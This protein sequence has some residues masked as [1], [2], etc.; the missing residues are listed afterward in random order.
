MLTTDASPVGLG[1]CLAHRITDENSGRS[2]L[3]PL[4]YASCSLKPSET[5]YAQI[6]R[7]GLAVYWAIKHFRQFLYCKKFELHTDCSALT[8]IF[9]PKSDLGGCAIGR[10][11]RW[12]VALMEYDFTAKHIKGSDN[13]ICDSLSRL[14][15]PPK[16][17]NLATLPQQ[18]GKSITSEELASNMSIKCLQYEETESATGIMDIVKCL[19]QLPGPKVEEVTICKVIGNTTNEVWE[20]FPLTAK[21]VATATRED[22]ILGKLIMAIRSGELN[23]KDIDLKPYI[24]IFDN[25]YIENDVIFH[26][27]RMLVPAKQ[28]ARLLDEL[29]TTHIGMVAM[30]KAARLQFWWPQINSEIEKISKECKGCNRFRKKPSPAPLCSWPFALRSLERVHIDFCEFKGKMLLVMIDAFSKFIWVHVMNLDTTTLKTLAVLYTWFTER[31]FPRTLV[32]DIR[33]TVYS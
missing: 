16:G 30:K 14:P 9:G 15:M 4:S 27:Q 2:Y 18:T 19:S 11:N 31:G 1:A 33:P 3:K 25:L 17:S 12:A 21:N 13:K 26:G 7:E 24:S 22:K 28:R 8:R 20:K 5:R 23:K 32:S 29:H 6:D 10:L